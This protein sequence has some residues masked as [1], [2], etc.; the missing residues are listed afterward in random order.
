MTFAAEQWSV[1]KNE[2]DPLWAAHYSELA[3]DKEKVHL[4]PDYRKYQVHSD[5]GMLEIM[6]A[7]KDG[8]LVG[9][10]FSLVDT[11]LHYATTLC[12]FWD[13]YFLIPEVRKGVGLSIAKHPGITLFREAEKILRA[14]GVKK[15][16]SGTKLWHDAG[17]LFEYLGWNETERL[18][19]KW[20][21]E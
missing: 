19:T 15:M 3:Q 4:A 14:R 5:N 21:G 13:L 2:I 10:V 18:F 8:A 1:I 16:F 11:H 20:I 6:A 17:E 9:Y 7:R 12:G